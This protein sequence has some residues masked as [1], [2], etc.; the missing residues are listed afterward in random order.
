MQWQ[1]NFVELTVRQLFED[2]IGCSNYVGLETAREST[3]SS[4]FHVL[5]LIIEIHRPEVIKLVKTL[6]SLSKYQKF[7]AYFR[8]PGV[9]KSYPFF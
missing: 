8:L 4:S 3:A 1:P 5:T 7:S 2:V 9:S 6:V